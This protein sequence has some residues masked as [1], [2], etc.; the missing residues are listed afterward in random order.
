MNDQ[1]LINIWKKLK[2]DGKVKVDYTTWKRNFLKEGSKAPANVYNYLK[3]KNLVTVSPNEWVKNITTP[4]QRESKSLPD[5]AL[6]SD[7]DTPNIVA[8][9]V[10]GKAPDLTAEELASYR[11]FSV[12][13]RVEEEKEKG[14]K[15]VEKY[16]LN[17]FG[18]TDPDA[19]V[20][21]REIRKKQV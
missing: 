17:T 1:T 21:E 20:R 2:R 6:E 8:P 18:T 7:M 11:D 5:V 13:K 15:G 19:P 3:N 9:E 14:R 10:V 12:D 4:P 16:L